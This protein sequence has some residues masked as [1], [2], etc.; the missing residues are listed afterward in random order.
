MPTIVATKSSTREV[1][2]QRRSTVAVPGQGTTVQVQTPTTA[3]APVTE[4]VRTIGVGSPGPQGPK[5]DPGADG[6][7]TVVTKVAAQTLGGHRIVRSVNGL[8]DYA[9]ATVEAHGDDVLGLTLG[10]VDAGAPV[11]VQTSGP[12]TEPSWNWTPGEALFLRE[13]GLMTQ[14]P[15]ADPAFDLVVGF[16]ET[17]TTV[18]ISLREPIFH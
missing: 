13:N 2:V 7:K 15:L 10:A 16:A 5:G 9:D 8:V 1:V 17:A 14:T 6:D 4:K 12:V 18:F 11:Q 3:L